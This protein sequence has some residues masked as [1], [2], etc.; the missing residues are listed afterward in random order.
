MM[1][2]LKD[3]NS[4]KDLSFMRRMRRLGGGGGSS[5]GSPNGGFGRGR[6]A[7]VNAAAVAAN[8]YSFNLDEIEVRGVITGDKKTA[9]KVR[10]RK[11]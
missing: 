6:P 8:H 9:L 11:E 4:S 10:G 1:A 2:D 3:F 7:S 5:G